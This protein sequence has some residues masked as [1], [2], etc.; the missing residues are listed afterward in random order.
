MGCVWAEGANVSGLPVTLSHATVVPA[1]P[2]ADWIVTLV[3]G[4]EITS[5][6]MS[7]IDHLVTSAKTENWKLQ[8]L[9]FRN[10]SDLTS[11]SPT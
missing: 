6:V 8:K 10:P 1:V 7:D 5:M 4:G 9:D 11:M 2:G 3:T